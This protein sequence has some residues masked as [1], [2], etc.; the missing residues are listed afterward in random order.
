M[1]DP[2]SRPFLSVVIPAYNEERRLPGTLARV[3]EYLAQQSY[4]S[5]VIVVDDGSTDRTAAIVE[6]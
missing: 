6:E 2:T 4:A 3:V 1:T 5:E